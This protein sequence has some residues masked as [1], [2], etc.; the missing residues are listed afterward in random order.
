M[1]SKQRLLVL[2]LL[3]LILSS[4]YAQ[5]APTQDLT[6]AISYFQKLW[7]TQVLYDF[8]NKPEGVAISSEGSKAGIWIRNNWIR[9]AGNPKLTNYFN[10]LGINH[11]DDISEIILT[12][13]HRHLNHRPISL[14]KQIAHYKTYWKTIAECET[15]T[16]KIA[17]L[18]YN[19]FKVGDEVLIYMPVDISNDIHN[20]IIYSCP[21][22]GFKFNPKIDLM[23]R[24]KILEKYTRNSLANVFFKVRIIKLSRTDTQI[25]MSEAK[26]G[27]SKELPLQGLKIEKATN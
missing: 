13:L 11:P 14:D 18:H 7:K 23:I 12:S 8:K 9:G 21:T 24:A 27:S 16:K 22:F 20:A 25:L 15:H 17:V 5:M 4:S 19:K 3:T 6:Q 1:T 26:V 10:S 2:L